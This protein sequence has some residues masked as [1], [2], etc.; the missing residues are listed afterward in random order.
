MPCKLLCMSVTDPKNMNV[1]LSAF[2]AYTNTKRVI[3]T[4]PQPGIIECLDGIRSLA[5]F[6][7]VFGHVFFI[8][9]FFPANTIETMEVSESENKGLDIITEAKLYIFYKELMSL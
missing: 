3:S 7:V 2:S 8:F 9:N 5:L 6:W 1:L 4:K